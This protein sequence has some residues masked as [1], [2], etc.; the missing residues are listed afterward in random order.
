MMLRF[1]L[2]QSFEIHTYFTPSDDN[3]NRKIG[4]VFFRFNIGNNKT[5]QK[6]SW[7]ISYLTGYQMETV[8][9][10][11]YNLTLPN[12]VTTQFIDWVSTFLRAPSSVLTATKYISFL[13]DGSEFKKHLAPLTWH[14]FWP[15]L[16]LLAKLAE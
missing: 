8:F 14:N 13:L 6:L 5:R 11:N 15:G 7:T 2:H 9:T 10:F 12:D 16:T 1:Y 3:V 4:K